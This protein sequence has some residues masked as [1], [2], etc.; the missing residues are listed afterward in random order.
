V[1]D[2]HTHTTASDGS[3]SPAELVQ[4]AVSVGLEALGITDHDTFAGYDEAAP[5]ATAAALPLVCGI[6]LSTKMQ[7]PRRTV[8]LL[9]YFLSGPPAPA[10]VDW[11]I[12][13]QAARRD[14]NIRLAARLRTLGLDVHVEEVEAIGRSLAGRPHFARLLV[15]KGYVS[16]IRDAFDRYLDETAPGY[17]DREEPTLED[18]IR[19]VNDAGGLPSLAHPVRLG[20]RDVSEED[21]LIAS[22]TRMGLRAIEVYHSDHDTADR[23]RYFQI[24]MKYGL[25]ITGGSDFHGSNKPGVE[26]GRGIGGNL[27]IP[28]VVLDAMAAAMSPTG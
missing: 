28:R 3:F 24:A 20:K 18:A 6:E 1:I 4:A 21:E 9:G 27:H 12:G 14:R 15:N 7:Q 8:H 13:L 5:H 17:V 23:Q 16:S 19:R 25:K 22:F 26:L 10:F 11:L 2:L